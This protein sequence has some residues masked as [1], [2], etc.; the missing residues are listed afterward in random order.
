M[1]KELHAYRKSYE[2]GALDEDQV[3]DNPMDLF[4]KWFDE[5][6]Q[7]DTVEEVNAMMLTTIGTDGFPKGRIVLLKEVTS[8]G[9]IFYSNYF[10]E[11]GKGIA[12][13]PKAGITFFWP[14]LERQII[15]KG[16]ATKIGEAQSKRYFE[17]RPRGSQ[18]GAWASYQSTVVNS[19]QVLIDRQKEVETEYLDKAIPKP[20]YWGGYCIQPY[21]IEFWQ[22][23]PNR[24]HDRLLFQKMEEQWSMKRLSP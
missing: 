19:R 3:S 8:A 12:T 13:N 14:G 11:K 23:R 16:T 9:F 20:A 6:E 1:K 7:S 4:G 17:S 5:A 21:S 10:S 24:L 18:L 22:G 15:I 2:K